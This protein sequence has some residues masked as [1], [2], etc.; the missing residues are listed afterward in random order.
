MCDQQSL[1][2]ACAYAQSDQSLSLSLEYSMSVKLL[3]ELIWIFYAYKEAAEASPSLF[4]LKWHIVGN[5]MPWLKFICLVARKP[6]ISACKQQSRLAPVLKTFF[7]NVSYH[8]LVASLTQI[9]TGYKYMIGHIDEK[10]F[11]GLE[12]V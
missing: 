7:I 1:R 6:H 3:T 5:H 2:S 8:I 11:Y 9:L 10:L 4:M 12:P